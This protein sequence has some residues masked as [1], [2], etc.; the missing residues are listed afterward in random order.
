METNKKCQ[1]C[2]EEIKVDA[3]KCKHCNEWLDGRN[4]TIDTKIVPKK[5]SGKT[6]TVKFVTLHL[7]T[8]GIYPMFWMYAQWKLLKDKQN[9]NIS[10]FWRAFFSP[11][12]SGS[13]AS[14]IKKFLKIENITVSYSPVVIGISFFLLNILYRL[15]EQ[16]WLFGFLSFVPIFPMLE[17]MNEYYEKNEADLP[18]ASFAWWQVG[19]I[20]V[21]LL[22]LVLSVYGSTHQ[23]Y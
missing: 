23:G 10:P 21:G 19:L 7:A 2:G 5:Y 1:F 6:S 14:D 15:P 12:W 8:F 18:E 22:L 20:G 9:L 3:V 11:L 13:L 16:Y 17:V 4:K